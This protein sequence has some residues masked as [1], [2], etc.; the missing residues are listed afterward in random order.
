MK[1]NEVDIKIQ[2]IKFKLSKDNPNFLL[3]DSTEQNIS[4][5]SDD[6]IDLGFKAE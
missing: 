6:E 5:F 4:E 2:G 1:N 3:L